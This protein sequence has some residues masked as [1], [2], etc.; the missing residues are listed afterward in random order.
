MIA[1]DR[2]PRPRSERRTSRRG[3][4]SCLLRGRAGSTAPRGI[5]AGRAPLRRDACSRSRDP[6]GTGPEVPL[7]C[8]GDGEVGAGDRGGRGGSPPRGVGVWQA[9]VWS[10]SGWT[11]YGRWPRWSGCSWS[12]SPGASGE[13][14][15]RWRPSPSE[16]P[17]GCSGCCWTAPKQ[18]PKPGEP[19]FAC[20]CRS[21]S[22]SS[23]WL[24][25]TP[26]CVGGR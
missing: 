20:S 11:W 12:S 15:W 26:S 5:V 19:A 2:E 18:W 4:L 24:P 1:G 16:P 3:C 14:G 8:S 13:V 25:R 9:P 17:S 21:T 7:H 10:R 23:R 6:P 22:V